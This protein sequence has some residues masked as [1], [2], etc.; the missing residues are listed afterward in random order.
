MSDERIYT[1]KEIAQVLLGLTNVYF[2]KPWWWRWTF[3]PWY[4]ALQTAGLVLCGPAI[5]E[6]ASDIEMF[7]AIDDHLDA[8]GDK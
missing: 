4:D 5:M 7:E 3:K 1:D 2:S 6:I 8:E